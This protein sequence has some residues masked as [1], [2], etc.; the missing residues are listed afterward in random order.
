MRK[1]LQC[2]ALAAAFMG[3]LAAQAQPYPARSI[4]MITPFAPGG[5]SDVVARLV[6]EKLGPLLGQ[7]VV[8]ENRP[9]ASGIIGGDVVAKAP[10]DGYTVL[11]MNSAITSNPWLYRKLPYDTERDF[12]PV[13]VLAS[14]PT[15]L[16]ANPSAPFNSVR[17]LT[18]YA[19]AHPATVSIGT[20]GAGQLS[21]LAGEM[22]EQASNT[23]MM[24]VHYKGTANSMSDLLGGQIMMS[25]GTVPGFVN[26]IRAGKL[27]AIAVA[28]PRR[29]AALPQVPTVAET[30]P[31]FE[32]NVWFGLFLPAGTPPDV[33]QTLNRAINQVL[34]DPVIRKR[35]GEEGLEPGGGSAAEFGALFRK[36]LAY[37]KGFIKERNIQIEK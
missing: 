24:M 7:Q 18:D 34:A 3:A 35:F 33:G 25:F 36:D 14:A 21:H 15:L 37:W 27:K 4:R 16:A 1:I 20:P 30:I 26:Q 17:E 23:T 31:G 8:V 2:C 19:R 11:M 6:A 13:I 29:L 22:L 32:V 5:G 12:I 10:P 28:S 9:G